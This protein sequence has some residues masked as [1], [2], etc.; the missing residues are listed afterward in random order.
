MVNQV[1]TAGEKFAAQIFSTMKFTNRPVFCIINSMKI[2]SLKQA[3]ELGL[4]PWD[5]FV[6]QIKDVEIHRDAYP[7][8]PGHSLFI[9]LNNTLENIQQALSL[10]YEWGYRL[11]QEAEFPAFNLGMNQGL[12]AGQTIMYPH[13]HLIP[14]FEND[15]ADPQGGVRGVIP[16]KQRYRL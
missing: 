5:C 1:Y 2:L 13:V 8:S 14:R 6:A 11:Q 4:A 9:P 10:A 7:V 15:V 12:I 3:R 16:H